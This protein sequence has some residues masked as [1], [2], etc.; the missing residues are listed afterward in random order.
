MN[1][2]PFCGEPIVRN[3]VNGKLYRCGTFTNDYEFYI[4]GHTC[5]IMTYNRL[6]DSKNSEIEELKKRNKTLWDK[7]SKYEH[8]LALYEEQIEELEGENND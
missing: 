7:I 4:T 6:L 5:D 3:S 1:K 2:C 8:T